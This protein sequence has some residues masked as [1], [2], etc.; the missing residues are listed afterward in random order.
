MHSGSHA[1]EPFEPGVS[2]IHRS[3]ERFFVARQLRRLT[4]TGLLLVA[5]C[6][7][8]FANPAVAQEQ[9]DSVQAAVD[10]LLTQQHPD[11]GFP[12]FT[13]E[14]DPGATIDAIFALV[15]A[16]QLGIAADTEEAVRYLQPHTLVY[17]Q[18]GPGSAA[19][20][21]LALVATG[22]DPRNFDNVNPLS[23]VEVA[24]GMGMIGQ[25][26]FDH[27]LG[28]QALV[29]AGVPVPEAAIEAAQA[30]QNEDFGWAW[31]G[32][33]TSGGGDT[34]TTAMMVQGLLAAGVRTAWVDASLDYLLASQNDD[35]GFPYQPGA[36]SDANSTALVL[37]ALI[38]AEDDAHADA[39]ERATAALMAMQNDSGAFF[40]MA[41]APDDNQFATVQ[42][43][44]ALAGV[45]FPLPVPVAMLP[46][47]EATPAG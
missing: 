26:P 20:M 35:G 6:L 40:Y 37:Q 24:A 1:L 27:A 23:I 7:S 3:R 46:T 44:P 34:N 18:V 43:I 47:P 8:A 13:G 11:G 41:S 21:V 10:W 42:A 28:L 31:D 22:N 25:G 45:A 16:Q 30:S 2:P 12:G 32:S 29:A 9:R 36:E 17:A 19:K 39:R 33:T 38:A 5:L 15:A 14:S 4:V